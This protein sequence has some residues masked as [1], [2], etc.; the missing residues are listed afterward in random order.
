MVRQLPWKSNLVP[1]HLS[2]FLFYLS[3][4]RYS[5]PSRRGGGF[6][7]VQ[8]WHMLSLSSSLWRRRLNYAGL[9][10]PSSHQR[11]SS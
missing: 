5:P 9:A 2:S 3:A 4:K 1:D 10:R 11:Y 8:C 7:P 6:V